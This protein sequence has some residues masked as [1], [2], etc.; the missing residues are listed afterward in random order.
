[1]LLYFLL[2]KCSALLYKKVL[3]CNACIPRVQVSGLWIVHDVIQPDCAYLWPSFGSLGGAYFF[4]S[5]PSLLIHWPGHLKLWCRGFVVEE[6]ESG[7]M[8][9]LLTHF[10][11][12]FFP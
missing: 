7:L 12:I 10:G 3:D 6:E 5:Q 1:M 9:N 8:K 2:D 4:Q 11:L